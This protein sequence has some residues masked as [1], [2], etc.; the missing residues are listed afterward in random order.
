MTEPQTVAMQR[1]I[2]FLYRGSFIS[3]RNRNA[4]LA[5][6]NISANMFVATALFM[7]IPDEI[8]KGTMINDVPPVDTP[9]TLTARERRQVIRILAAANLKRQLYFCSP[10]VA[11]CPVVRR[12]GG[13]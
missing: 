11:G 3:F 13:L 8:R 9:K 7:G 2:M 4:P 1:R 5:L 10:D 12:F 6:K